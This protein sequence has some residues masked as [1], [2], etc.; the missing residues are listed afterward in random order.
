MMADPDCIHPWPNGSVCAAC[1]KP[2][3]DCGL[4]TFSGDF[5]HLMADAMCSTFKKMTGRDASDQLHMSLVAAIQDDDRAP[6]EVNSMTDQCAE[7]TDTR[8]CT[9]PPDDSPPVPCP[10]KY[11]LTEC[12]TAAALTSR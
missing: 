8:T 5:V 2:W 11:A 12:R 9:C 6:D 3:R 4:G 7:N 10:R 1:G